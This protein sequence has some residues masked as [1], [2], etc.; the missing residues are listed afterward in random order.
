[1]CN[2]ITKLLILPSKRRDSEKV[3]LISQDSVNDDLLAH[4]AFRKV[5]LCIEILNPKSTSDS[6]SQL[7]ESTRCEL[8]FQ[9]E[10]LRP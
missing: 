3:G 7:L 6:G 2:K 4:E 1:M 5:C 9:N 10:A 8:N